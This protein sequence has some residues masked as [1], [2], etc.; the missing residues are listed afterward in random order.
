MTVEKHSE[1]KYIEPWAGPGWSMSI[2][3]STGRMTAYCS[4]YTLEI[5]GPKALVRA[6]IEEI[7]RCG[8]VL[9]VG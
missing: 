8:G 9:E 4:E 2:S 6:V 1:I 3:E 7:D 5:V